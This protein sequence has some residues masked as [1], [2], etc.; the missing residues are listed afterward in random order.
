MSNVKE[1]GNYSYV[2]KFKEI[3]GINIETDK[4]VTVEVKEKENN[5]GDVA[6]EGAI[7]AASPPAVTGNDTEGDD[8]NSS[9]E[10]NNVSEEKSDLDNKN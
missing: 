4:A 10:I 1:I 7:D 9:A 3:D 2:I 6:S 5:S 8:T